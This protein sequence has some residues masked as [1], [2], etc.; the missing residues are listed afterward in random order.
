MLDNLAPAYAAIG[1]QSTGQVSIR[2]W[3]DTAS[4]AAAGGSG[5]SMS[6][7]AAVNVGAAGLS[8]VNVSYY[9]ATATGP[10]WR[11]PGGPR[12]G[13]LIHLSGPLVFTTMYQA[14]RTGVFLIEV[15]ADGVPVPQSPILVS[16]QPP[17]CPF[18]GQAVDVNGFC[19]CAAP[20]TRV[21]P[22]G[23]C[24]Y[25]AQLDVALVAGPVVG[26]VCALLLCAGVTA[27][28]YMKY[29]QRQSYIIPLS[30]IDL[31]HSRVLGQG[32]FGQVV[33]GTYNGATVALKRA[34]VAGR[35]K[36]RSGRNGSAGVRRPGL[37]A[38]GPGV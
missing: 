27:F 33:T 10:T 24:D 22:G 7:G 6:T 31:S 28:R 26:G 2:F 29:L 30:K 12:I 9:A 3:G 37:G 32:S 4:A 8:W 13:S 17:E 5:S 35:T 15:M 38:L 16:V 23:G 25:P 21:L 34:I 11:L 1:K 19:F 14:T 20:K 18:D 36:R